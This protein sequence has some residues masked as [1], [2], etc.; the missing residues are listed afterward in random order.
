VSI[1]AKLSPRATEGLD[2]ELINYLLEIGK[3]MDAIADIAGGATD[4]TQNTKINEILAAL[5]DAGK[6][7]D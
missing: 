7:V 2:R 6:M 4:A 1:R 3:R 5:R